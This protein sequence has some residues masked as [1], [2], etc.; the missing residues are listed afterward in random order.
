MHN[1]KTELRGL[2]NK[3]NNFFWVSKNENIVSKKCFQKLKLNNARFQQVI[4]LAVMWTKN[5]K[6][7]KIC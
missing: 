4:S 6:R 7:K 3:T 5:R 1:L 2:T